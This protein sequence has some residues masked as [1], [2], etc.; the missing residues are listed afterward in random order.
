M[1]PRRVKLVIA[2][3]LFAFLFGPLFE[4]FDRWDNF[5]QKS[6]DI[7]LS[8]SGFVTFLAAVVAFA[9]AFRRRI[10]GWAR[11]TAV[12]FRLNSLKTNLGNFLLLRPTINFHS[13]PLI[14]RI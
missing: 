11:L 6:D 3:V 4:T 10:G 12:F 5:P 1:K 9:L 7:A 8:T 14:L 2:F 13:P